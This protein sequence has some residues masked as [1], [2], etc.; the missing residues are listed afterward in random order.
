MESPPFFLI[1]RCFRQ[2]EKKISGTMQP[3][4]CFNGFYDVSYLYYR[5]G[6]KKH[7]YFAGHWQENRCRTLKSL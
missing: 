6:D 1:F 4:N 2:N 7:G 3:V 5:K